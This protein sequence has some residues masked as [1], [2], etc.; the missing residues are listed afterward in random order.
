MLTDDSAVVRG[1][2]HRMLAAEPDITVVASVG[3][4][5]HAVSQLQRDRSIE[6]IILD[7]EMPVMDG[8]TALKQLLAIEPA[9]QVIMA[10]TLTQRNAEIS[11][12]AIA[13]GATDYIPKP[14]ADRLGGADAFRCELVAKIRAFGSRRRRSGG[15]P[16]VRAAAAPRPAVADTPVS[17]GGRAAATPLRRASG[18]RPEVVAIGCSTGG[19]QAL[20][21]LF[22]DLP[23]GSIRQPILITQHMPPAFTA[24]LA[25][26]IATATGWACDEARDGDPLR[27]GAIHVAPGDHH[28]L[29][30]GRR[31]QPVIRLSRE[32]PVNFC[33]PSVD[34]MLH[35]AVTVFGGRILTIILTGMGSDGTAGARSVVA[36]GGTVIAQDEATSVVWGM[37]GAVAQAGLCAAIL[38]LTGL[39]PAIVKL[40]GGGML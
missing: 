23:P 29:I 31:D 18:Q 19:P 37:P 20:T 25:K 2:I 22:K 26:H 14:V 32:A 13:A 39:A 4:G 36:A 35:T 6:V 3:N 24:I 33:R 30:E 8:L 40:A 21:A 1:L 34:P 9:V 15:G 11:L 27:P 28:M 7:V 10:S 38:P 16:A 5:A 12:Q 17:A